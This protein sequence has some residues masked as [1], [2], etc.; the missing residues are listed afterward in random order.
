MSVSEADGITRKMYKT[1]SR[2][3]LYLMIVTATWELK[4]RD[5]RRK[6]SDN[7]EDSEVVE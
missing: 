3:D 5:A 1:M 7:E 6:K 2:K 4:R